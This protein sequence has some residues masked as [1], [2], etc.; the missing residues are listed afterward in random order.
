[1][2]G[3]W[4]LGP[5]L[6]SERCTAYLQEGDEDLLYPVSTKTLATNE[7]QYN[8]QSWNVF[9]VV[10][11]T[12]AA[13]PG[14][15][16]PSFNLEIVHEP[17]NGLIE[18]IQSAI[19]HQKQ[20]VQQF[21]GTV[22]D[23][24][25]QETLKMTLSGHVDGDGNI[26]RGSF[27]SWRKNLYRDEAKEKQRSVRNKMLADESLNLNGNA[28]ERKQAIDDILGSFVWEVQREIAA[29]R[30][31]KRK[32]AA[33]ISRPTLSRAFFSWKFA[34]RQSSIASMPSSGLFSEP[35]LP[36]N[37]RHPRSQF[38]GIW[39][40]VQAIIL[41]YVAFS[42]IWRVCF[43]V[44][45]EG[46]MA[47][48]EALIDIY[49]LA[50]VILNLH[51]A[52]YDQSG[53]LI[54][55]APTNTGRGFWPLLSC[56]SGADLPKTYAK[57]ARGWLFIDV[58]SIFPFAWFARR[59]WPNEAAS[60][61][62]A[63]V[64]KVLRLLRL[65]KLLRLARA[66]R[67]FKKYEEELGPLVSASLLVG[68]V[69]LIIHAIACI[70]FLVGTTRTYYNSHECTK[71]GT[72]DDEPIIQSHGWVEDNFAGSASLCGCRTD[73]HGQPYFYDAYES[74]C[75]HPMN[76]SAPIEK[77]CPGAMKPDA[78]TYYNKA[79]FTAMQDTN[80]GDDYDHGTSELLAAAGITAVFGFLW[81]AVAGAWS[82]I[83]AANAMAGQEFRKKMVEVKEFCRLKSLDWGTRAKL[84]AYYDH[85]YPDGVIINEHEI[86]SDL[87]PTMKIEL[88]RSIYGSVILAVPLFF[89]LD[90]T[91]L[92]EI[93]LALVALPAMKGE[94]ILRE[95]QKG[96]EMY[97][98]HS[99]Q[100]RVSQHMGGGD[101]EDRVRIWI[102]EVFSAHGK[103]LRLYEPNQ[104][105]LLNK[106]L[107][108]MQSRGWAQALVQK[109]LKKRILSPRGNLPRTDGDDDTVRISYRELVNDDTLA[110]SF[111]AD[112]SVVDPV[113]TLHTLLATAKK[114]KCVS[115]S[116]HLKLSQNSDG[117]FDDGPIITLVRVSTAHIAWDTPRHMLCAA[118]RDG[119]V[120]CDLLNFFLSFP[121]VEVYREG[122][123]LQ[124]I[125][126]LASDAAA[127]GDNLV[128]GTTEMAIKVADKSASMV[129]DAMGSKQ[130]QKGVS[131]INK[132]QEN[133][134][135]RATGAANA[136][137]SG[138]DNQF[139]GS[140]RNLGNFLGVL[141]DPNRAFN[142]GELIVQSMNTGGEAGQHLFNMEDLL[143]FDQGIPQEQSEKQKR[144]LA[145][146]LEFALVISSMDGYMGTKLDEVN[147]GTLTAGEF[148]G[149]LALLPLQGGWRHHRTCTAAGNV[150]LYYL[151][152][153]KLEHIASQYPDLKHKL[154]DHA[155]DYEK[156]QASSTFTQQ[157]T[158]FSVSDGQSATKSTAEVSTHSLAQRTS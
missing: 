106:L 94:I 45:A 115:Y 12:W 134:V 88:V 83:F 19:E 50:D 34:C 121:K 135:G 82:T 32:F 18:Y 144:V 35:Q 22:E 102:E 79:L 128:T 122:G 13:A 2:D 73:V 126:G 5:T 149:E 153:Q 57:Y 140:K 17:G 29:R 7:E 141:S 110:S 148:F 42:V 66:M 24:A 31:A 84:I 92:T 120:L 78:W 30:L 114:H 15:H 101:D 41:I 104:R 89:G 67:I 43:N 81:G 150:M 138:L 85:L 58:L 28:E 131:G 63:K 40:G 142:T 107:K 55:L 111:T 3:V 65:S 133:T 23:G 25:K 70:W 48:L 130:L 11:K 151:T 157:T 113:A 155:E 80:I 103:K 98:I 52:Y 68:A 96:T 156:M 59:I 77:V 21:E 90:S 64:L 74:F 136:A 54:G 93:C 37:V 129:P 152:R 62:D 4:V 105:K 112:R 1:M 75:L 119:I 39:E 132:I 146:L 53:D 69:V 44:P 47:V 109:G 9:D 154:H 108:R 36:W 26:S 49:F 139:V 20:Y 125:T 143:L 14:D 97:C 46:W 72:C 147:L 137:T 127:I 10:A 71:E 60:G 86:M 100:C 16:C 33:R 117:S 51:T 95:G 38:T 61:A 8:F 116:G 118:L 87:P 124:L 76:M 6:N 56:G 123:A 158:K 27:L 99:G 91:I 145:C